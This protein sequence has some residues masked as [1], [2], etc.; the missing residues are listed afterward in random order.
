MAFEF[1]SAP[2]S[3]L[4]PCP[5]YQPTTPSAFAATPLFTPAG[6]AAPAAQPGAAFRRLDRLAPLLMSTPLLVLGRVWHAH[7]AAHSIG[8]AALLGLLSAAGGTVGCVAAIAQAPVIA[9]VALAVGGGLAAAAIAGYSNSLSLPLIT[10]AVAT[11]SAYAV[12]WRSW[13]ADARREV[14]AGHESERLALECSTTLQTEVIRAQRDIAVAQISA[15]RDVRVAELTGRAGGEFEARYG[16]SSAPRVAPVDPA[17]LELSPAAR[18]ALEPTKTTV[19][20][21]QVLGVE[22][23]ELA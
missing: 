17:L 6:P 19:R 8:D 3:A 2:G 23:A 9:G 5:H 4:E 22:D 7:G 10:W 11:L 20:V 15:A 18:A 14:E 21:E 1:R 12:A 13:R 16:L